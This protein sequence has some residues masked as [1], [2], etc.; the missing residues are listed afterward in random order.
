[1]SER[2]RERERERGRERERERERESTLPLVFL[3]VARAIVHAVN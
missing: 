2:E 3:P 1:M